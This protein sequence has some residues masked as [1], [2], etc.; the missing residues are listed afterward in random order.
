MRVLFVLYFYTHKFSLV[1]EVFPSSEHYLKFLPLAVV[2]VDFLSV[3]VVFADVL[4]HTCFLVFLPLRY[5]SLHVYRYI[6]T[7]T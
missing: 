1:F 2:F 7:Y 5:T 4:I 6:Y 3:A